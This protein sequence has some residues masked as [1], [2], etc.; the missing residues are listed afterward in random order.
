MV[1]N[2]CL[3]ERFFSWM[4]W[5]SI[6]FAW[7][8]SS[9]SEQ[10]CS[11]QG[12]LFVAACGVFHCGDFSCCRARALGPQPSVVAAPGLTSCGMWEQSLQCMG[13]I[14]PQH[15][16]SYRNRDQTRVPCITSWIFIHCTTGEVLLEDF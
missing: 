4:H 12:L 8:F 10:N 7:A 3:F 6:A 14:V 5:V 13:F 1:L 15:V 2:F 16:E 11:E 9:C